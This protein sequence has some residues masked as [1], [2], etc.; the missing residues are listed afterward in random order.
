LTS[1]DTVHTEAGNT[2]PSKAQTAST[3]LHRLAALMKRFHKL[4]H[5]IDIEGRVGAVEPGR[6]IVSG[7]SSMAELGDL[8]VLEAP[9]GLIQAEIIRV[10]QDAVVAKYFQHEVGVKLG[11][12]ARLAQ[13][14]SVTV[15]N[16]AKGRV[17]NA[18][19]EPIDGLAPLAQGDTRPVYAS[20]PAA[21]RRQPVG[22]TWQTGIMAVD[23]FTPLCLGQRIGIFSGSG[24]GKST[25]L[26]MMRAAP[27]FDTVIV[28]LI[29]ERGWEARAAFD[30][31]SDAERNRT[32]GI[33]STSDEPA[34]C[35]RLAALTATTM[36][37]A[38]RDRGER[39]LLVM[40]SLTRYALASREIG[41]AAGELPVARGHVPSVFAGLSSLLERAGP[42][43][44]ANGSISAVYTVLVEG[45]DHNDPI[46]DAVRGTLDGHIVLDRDVMREGRMPA[47]DL[48]SSLSRLQD[49]ALTREQASLANRARAHLASAWENRD[50]IALSP[51]EAAANTE[52]QASIRVANA[53]MQRLTQRPEDPWVTEPFEELAKL[54][55]GNESAPTEAV[56]PGTQSSQDALSAVAAPR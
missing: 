12:R 28:A 14:L 3:R 50:L 36:A 23:V 33:V 54:L 52:L 56:S 51:R 45:D 6:I 5:R 9:Q 2:L 22:E 1:P 31:L 19:G 48:V 34:M 4:R 20:A 18:F 49:R 39:V 29:G 55:E 15:S 8:L 27:A 25:L 40:D 44:H 37:E 11:M 41:L 7:L 30:S 43:L 10:D 46:A 13:P 42:G 21:M 53:L 35:R 47:I 26:S 24:V 32:I 17:L 38:C 16:D